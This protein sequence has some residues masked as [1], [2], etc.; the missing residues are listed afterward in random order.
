M[1]TTRCFLTLLFMLSLLLAYPQRIYAQDRNLPFLQITGIDVSNQPNVTVTLYGENLNGN[2]ASLRATLL[3]DGVEQS[4]IS[5]QVADV[6]IQTAIVID[7]NSLTLAG[8]TGN[9]GYVEAA[10]AVA[11]FVQLGVLS[12]G[13]DWLSAYAPGASLT[14]TPVVAGWQQDH[15]FVSNALLQYQPPQAMLEGGLAEQIKFVLDQFRDVNRPANLPANLQR[16][17]ILFSH[18]TEVLTTGQIDDITRLAG[19]LRVRIHVVMLG[20]DRADARDNLVRLVNRT[21]GHF[22]QLGAVS[23]LVEPLWRQTLSAERT[24]RVLRYRLTT[25]HPTT[26][27]VIMTLPDGRQ[28]TSQASIPSITVQPAQVEVVFPKEGQIFQ[29]TFNESVAATTAESMLPVQLTITW[30]DGHPRKLARVEYLLDNGVYP[31]TS[32][33]FGQFSLPISAQITDGAH[34]LRVIVVDELGI[35][36]NSA[37]VRIDIQTE[38]NTVPN[39]VPAAVDTA[40]V[41]N[42]VLTITGVSSVVTSTILTGVAATGVTSDVTDTTPAIVSPDPNLDRT[43]FT[44]NITSLPNVEFTPALR[45]GV[46]FASLLGLAVIVYGYRRHR[47]VML[48]PST[49]RGQS[50]GDGA[51]TRSK[52]DSSHTPE[53]EELSSTVALVQAPQLAED[54]HTEVANDANFLTP[55]YLVYEAG[56]DHLPEKVPLDSRVVRIGRKPAFCDAVINDKRISKL[57]CTIS[58]REEGFYIRDDGSTG[59]TAVNRRRLGVSDQVKLNHNDLINLHEIVYRFEKTADIADQTGATNDAAIKVTEAE[60]S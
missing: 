27:D 2:L 38:N 28:V 35:Q 18:G 7:P 5:D 42:A 33:P 31:Q 22:V 34:T 23:D 52:Q 46:G 26:L 56:G 1:R 60:A 37:P 51:V 19:E 11:Q 6:G 40:I 12:A 43:A 59:G 53:P 44:I 13:T 47:K 9:P 57:H 15:V 29:R 20:R 39:P 45:L 49:N 24:Q 25:A 16:S 58:E 10:N 50:Q 3:Q 41:N 55:A 36:A 21:Q 54:E 30:P 32:E 14:G 48:R 17:L 8:N 4:I